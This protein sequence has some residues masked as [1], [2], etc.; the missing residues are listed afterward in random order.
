MQIQCLCDTVSYSCRINNTVGPLPKLWFLW[1]G[2]IAVNG[3][4]YTTRPPHNEIKIN[5]SYLTTRSNFLVK[6][7]KCLSCPAR[8]TKYSCSFRV[9]YSLNHGFALTHFDH[10]SAVANELAALDR[11]VTSIQTPPTTPPST[12]FY[13]TSGEE[14]HENN[15]EMP[16]S[17][18]D[19]MKGPP[20]FLHKRVKRLTWTPMA[21][22]VVSYVWANQ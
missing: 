7:H 15:A 2:H 11:C 21:G 13:W 4:S 1:I 3:K 10:R 17:G 19:W 20:V 8:L 22:D 18:C 12:R 9:S 14:F 5:A 16:C 6:Q